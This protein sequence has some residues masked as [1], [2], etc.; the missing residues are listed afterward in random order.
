[1]QMMGPTA[2]GCSAYEIHVAYAGQRESKDPGIA[3]CVILDFD[4]S[5]SFMAFHCD[6]LLL[7]V[8]SKYTNCSRND[9]GTFYDNT[10]KQPENTFQYM[11]T[12][13]RRFQVGSIHKSLL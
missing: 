12:F 7:C 8:C 1:M 3:S 13:H 9:S 10:C 6:A 5:T 4:P 2:C 11:L